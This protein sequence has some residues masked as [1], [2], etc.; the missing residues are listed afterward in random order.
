MR[1]IC[2][3]LLGLLLVSRPAIAA[4]DDPLIA[5][6]AR[7]FDDLAKAD[8]ANEARLR[9]AAKLLAETNQS[10]RWTNYGSATAILRQTRS[11]AAVPLLM[12]YCIEHA[13]YGS[14][15]VIVPEY[16]STLV[17][18]TGHDTGIAYQYG[19]NRVTPI[20]KAV[21]KAVDEWWNP[22]RKSIETQ[23]AKMPPANARAAALRLIDAA[24]KYSGDREDR[25]ATAY[26]IYHQLMPLWQGGEGRQDRSWRGQIDAAIVPYLLEHIGYQ[27]ADLKP[28]LP[29]RLPLETVAM[30]AALRADR[31]ADIL[32]KVVDDRTQPAMARLCAVLAIRSAGEKLRT[33]VL[34]AIPDAEKR[35][36][37]RITA[38]LALEQSRQDVHRKLIEFT[39]D[40][41]G[42]IVAAACWA[43]RG[44]LH[45]EVVPSL[46]LIIDRLEPEPALY[47]AI[48]VL[49]RIKG[50]ESAATALADFLAAGLED[51]KRARYLSQALDSF[52]T[53]TDCPT[54]SARGHDDA[55]MK[56]AIR[57]A[58]KWWRSRKTP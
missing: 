36:D 21:Q 56:A 52:V 5:Q 48:D 15:H 38:I 49:G 41:N 55:A 25:A 12:R 8:P 27:T 57:D 30:L 28:V 1:P 29:K 23:W 37:V 17:I 58:V 2:L 13:G 7:D 9:E 50:D 44:S 24:E 33:D 40:P 14:G 43:M 35:L 45:P 20:R 16:A 39:D 18:L 46:K 32:T 22:Q 26:G 11:K 53:V 10:D 3:L 47:P 34:L 51:P 54:K 42:E 4:D 6:L 19:P 31:E